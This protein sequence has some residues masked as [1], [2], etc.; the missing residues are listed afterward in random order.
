MFIPLSS[1]H[2]LIKAVLVYAQISRALYWIV[3]QQMRQL[4]LW[5]HN[6]NII[7]III[8]IIMCTY[9]GRERC[10]QGFGGETWVKDTIGETKT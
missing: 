4:Y 8:N 10:A 3:H 5:F 2:A 6:L 9:G 7:I 1:K